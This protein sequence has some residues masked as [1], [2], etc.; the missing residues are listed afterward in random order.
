MPEKGGAGPVLTGSFFLQNLDAVENFVEV[1]VINVLE[2]EVA[3]VARFGPE[4]HDFEL[5]HLAHAGLLVLAV[6]EHLGE[7]GD[8]LTFL[9]FWRKAGGILEDLVGH[10]Q[11][12]GNAGV[13][14][15]DNGSALA[16]KVV[17]KAVVLSLADLFL[18]DGLDDAER[19]ALEFPLIKGIM[20]GRGLVASPALAREIRGGDVF[21]NEE[22]KAFLDRLYEGW[23]SDIGNKKIA[24]LRMK[25]IW[26]Y[27]RFSFPDREKEI[28]KLKKAKDTFEYEIAVREI[29]RG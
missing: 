24:M 25:E 12:F 13:V 4:Y 7:R 10:A 28:H 27:M 18:C 6:L 29:L 26:D 11:F 14:L 17:K 16:G 20:V 23:T 15:V 2:P 3:V 22:I 8:I 9:Q 21:S 19:I 1:I 5:V